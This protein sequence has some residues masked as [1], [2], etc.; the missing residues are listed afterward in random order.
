M[1][2]RNCVRRPCPQGDAILLVQDNFL[3]LSST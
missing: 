1:K 2:L 3:D